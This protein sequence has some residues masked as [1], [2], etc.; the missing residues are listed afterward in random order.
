MRSGDLENKM[1]IKNNEDRE[2]I[3]WK[4]QHGMLRCGICGKKLKRLPEKYFYSEVI[5]GKRHIIYLAE[6][7]GFSGIDLMDVHLKCWRKQNE[8]V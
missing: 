7:T 3:I 1:E 5:D 4:R 8:K 2:K 6:N